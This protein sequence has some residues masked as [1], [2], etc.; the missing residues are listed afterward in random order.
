MGN[1]GGENHHICDLTGMLLVKI[2]K[3][4]KQ[5]AVIRVRINEDSRQ[6]IQHRHVGNSSD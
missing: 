1:G 6:V 5:Q 2:K 3:I 4:M